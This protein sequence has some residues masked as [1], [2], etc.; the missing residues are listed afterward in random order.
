MQLQ[1]LEGRLRYLALLLSIMQ[2]VMMV[3]AFFGSTRSIFRQSKETS[4]SCGW[5]EEK[6]TRSRLDGGWTAKETIG[7]WDQIKGTMYGGVRFKRNCWSLCFSPHSLYEHALVLWLAQWR[8]HHHHLSYLQHHLKRVVIILSSSESGSGR[9]RY[10]ALLLSIMQTVMMVQ[11]FFGSTRSI[12]R[13]CQRLCLFVWCM[14]FKINY[15]T[16][17]LLRSTV[18]LVELW[19]KL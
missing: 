17:L 7:C 14:R 11:A 3:Q 4:G 15:L 1:S 18:V 13:Q 9:L 6:K 8:H 2:T 19:L 10:L 16:T 12:F 5:T